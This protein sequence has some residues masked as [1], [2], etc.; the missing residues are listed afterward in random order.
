MENNNGA[1]GQPQ[2]MNLPFASLLLS[3]GVALEAQEPTNAT[4]NTK[5]SLEV[6]RRS[7]RHSRHIQ[8]IQKSCGSKIKSELL[9]DEVISRLSIFEK[10][11]VIDYLQSL[12]TSEYVTQL[13]RCISNVECGHLSEG[14]KLDTLND[15]L[16]YSS[17]LLFD[18]F[19]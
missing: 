16:D 18:H 17:Y 4:L 6:L 10:S 3:T 1:P 7:S 11:E 2:E 5:F 9:V 8:F 14:V 13:I 12:Q 19:N 15:M